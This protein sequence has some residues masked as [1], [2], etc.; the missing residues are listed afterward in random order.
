MI[1]D[2]SEIT[3]YPF[4]GKSLNIGLHLIS[5]PIQTHASRPILFFFML[6][7]KIYTNN[8]YY[9]CLIII[10]KG[11]ILF[12]SRQQAVFSGLTKAMEYF[13]LEDS[14]FRGN[15]LIV[16]SGYSLGRQYANNK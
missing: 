15:A 10:F 6:Y 4:K 12:S 5:F 1:S 8:I 11:N 3:Y 2:K 13:C 16:T 9:M 7:M 14:L